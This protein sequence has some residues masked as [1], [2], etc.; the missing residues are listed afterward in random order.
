LP[1]LVSVT[2]DL[3]WFGAA[4][5]EL[6]PVLSR[7]IDVVSRGIDIVSVAALPVVLLVS[8]RIEAVSDL[9]LSVRI[10]VVSEDAP[11]SAAVRP[12]LGDT[13]AAPV[14]LL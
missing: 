1:V 4:P 2:P 3:V 6:V 8:R 14:S 13:L 11:V 12:L 9:V 5:A 10:R 7:F